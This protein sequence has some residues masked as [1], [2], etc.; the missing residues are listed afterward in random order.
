MWKS[1]S[2]KSHRQ[3]T[4]RRPF[5]TTERLIAIAAVAVTAFGFAQP[6]VLALAGLDFER[7]GL[8]IRHGIDRTPIGSVAKAL[9]SDRPENTIHGLA[10]TLKPLRS[11][12]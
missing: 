9:G 8:A 3:T 2:P 11:R 1:T 5:V 12:D 10:G 6:Q 4:Y 7:P